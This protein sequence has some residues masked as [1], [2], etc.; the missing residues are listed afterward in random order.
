M[1]TIVRMDST[2]KLN[3]EAPLFKMLRDHPPKWWIDLVNDPEVYIEIRKGNKIHAYYY[4]ARIAEITFNGVDISA[5]CNSKY[6]HGENAPQNRYESCI[7]MLGGQREL[8]KSN[9][10]KYYVNKNKKIGE[11]AED[12]SEKR[13]QGRLRIDNVSRYVDS[14][15]EY[16]YAQKG[17]PHTMIR[18]DLVAVDGNV[19]KIEELKRIGDSR[20]RTSDM[21]SNP[22]EVLEQMERYQKFMSVNKEAICA[23][24]QTLIGIKEQLGL[25]IPVDYDKDE[26]LMLDLTP[27]LLIKNLYRYSKMNAA[28]FDRIRDIRKILEDKK[29]KYNILP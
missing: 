22:P 27:L 6:I 7:H 1:D 17:N 9:A 8:L 3:P 29:I 5:S 18:F 14:E 24:Y 13:I 28:R 19:I 11:N 15:F 23:Y 20:L 26:P 2:L 12:T 21:E 10:L 4:G 16:E 25:P